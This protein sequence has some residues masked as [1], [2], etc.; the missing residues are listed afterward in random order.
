MS[1]IKKEIKGKAAAIINNLDDDDAPNSLGGPNW[2]DDRLDSIKHWMAG[3]SMFEG[4]LLP[5]FGVLSLLLRTTPV[6]VYNIPEFR[7]FARTAFTDGHHV[8]ICA[9]FMEKLEKDVEN[10]RGNVYGVEVLILHELMH[11]LFN[12]TKRLK[13]FPPELA[14]IGTDLSINTKLQLGF[15]EMEWCKTLK[16][17]GLGFKPGDVEKYATL[18]EETIC[19]ELLKT[20]K[21][22]SN[23]GKGQGKNKQG[24]GQQANK[25]KSTRTGST[26]GSTGQGQPGQGQPGQG[27]PG[28]GQPGQGQPGQGQP[29][30]GQPG[31]GQPGQGGEQDG[32]QQDKGGNEEP[33]DSFGAEGDNHLVSLEDVIET[34]EKAGLDSVREKLNLPKSSDLEEIGKLEEENEM[35]QVEAVQKAEAQMHGTG[36]K[37]PGAH[38]AEYASNL[39]KSGS[40]GKLSW[41]LAM[42]EAILGDGMKYKYN[43]EEPND[44]YYVDEVK[45]ATGVELYFGSD[46]PIKPDE[47]VLCLFDTSGSVSNAD[48]KAFLDETFELK[49]ASNG[50]G[51]AASEVVVLSA[52]TVLRGEPIEITENNVHQLLNEGVKIFGRGGTNLAH[53]LKETMKLPML[54]EKKIKTIIYFTDLFDIPPTRESLNLPDDTAVIFVAAPSTHSTHIEEFS[55]AVESYARVYPIREGL[56]VDLTEDY[57]SAPVLNTRSKA[58]P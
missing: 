57:K 20:Y 18:A 7:K 13:Q 16:E 15:P 29:G 23:D 11:K 46:L 38:I 3:D 33:P 8:F 43:L 50:A 10:S 39:V 22:K 47:H 32:N 24:Q 4:H 55:K 31:Q 2:L 40:K 5:R 49:L 52:D 34:L 58:K 19:R 9:E 56:E 12:H 45:E 37:Y 44:I 1:E 30:Q 41:R 35:R 14:N 6:Y 26:T 48:I 27:Q 42:R 53:S 51:D 28:Q 25:D 21:P 36:G 17:V 54:K